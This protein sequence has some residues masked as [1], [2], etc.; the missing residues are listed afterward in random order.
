MRTELKSRLTTTTIDLFCMINEFTKVH[1]IKRWSTTRLESDTC[2]F[3]QLS[4]YTNLFTPTGNS[5]IKNED[6]LN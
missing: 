4:F 1:N 5:Q 2:D 6:K 3:F